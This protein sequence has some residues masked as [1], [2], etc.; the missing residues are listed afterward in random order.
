MKNIVGAQHHGV[1]HAGQLCNLNPKAV[2]TAAFLQLAHEND[3]VA[4]FFH[5]RQI[6][7]QLIELMVVRSKQRFWSKVFVVVQILHNGLGK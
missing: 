5:A 7:R 6:L 2:F 1:R 4:H 3:L